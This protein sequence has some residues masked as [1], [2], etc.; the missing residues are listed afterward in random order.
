[1]N[2]SMFKYDEWINEII[3]R[4]FIENRHILNKIDVDTYYWPPI[5]RPRNGKK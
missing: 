5:A 3:N 4:I 2:H 1:M